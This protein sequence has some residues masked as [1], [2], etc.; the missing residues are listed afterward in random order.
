MPSF[1]CRFMSESSQVVFDTDID[2]KDLDAAK[3][4]AFN[5]LCAEPVQRLSLVHGLEI[6]Q[7]NHRLYPISDLPAP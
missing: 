4:A 6:W 1:H 3:H 5:V 7:G 2:A